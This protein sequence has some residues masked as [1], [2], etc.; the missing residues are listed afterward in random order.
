MFYHQLRKLNYLLLVLF[1][2][3]AVFGQDSLIIHYQNRTPYAYPESAT[4]RGIEVDIMNEYLLWLATKK[5]KPVGFRYVQHKDQASVLAAMKSGNAN[6]FGLTSVT[7]SAELSREVDF[8]VP[9]LKH[10]AFCVTNGNAPE[11]KNKT[12]DD[13][14]RVLG[15]MSALTVTNTSLNYY[16]NDLKKTYLQDL[17]TV[18]K[19]D[20]YVMMLEIS[21]N[22]LLFGYVDAIHFQYF[23]K[24]NPTKVL[25]IQKPLTVSK[26]PFAFA[27]PKNSNHRLLFNEFFTAFKT[28]PAYKAILEKHLGAYMAGNVSL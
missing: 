28:T 22:V 23:L 8:T 4:V 19:P 17:K 27:L 1:T 21:K 6:Y 2:S 3:V 10:V 13:V 25:K 9:Y 15:A 26:D 11:I 18:A 20:D 5:K 16:I 14:M 24:T 7:P 12:K